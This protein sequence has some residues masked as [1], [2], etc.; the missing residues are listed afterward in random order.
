M[1]R[2]SRA[3][4]P[5]SRI[6]R[7]ALTRQL[8]RKWSTTGSNWPGITAILIQGGVGGGGG[9]FVDGGAFVAVSGGVALIGVVAAGVL[10]GSG[11]P[12]AKPATR[13]ATWES[14]WRRLWRLIVQSVQSPLHVST[15][16]LPP[17]TAQ[18]LLTGLLR[19]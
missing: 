19:W 12:S 17:R 18:E 13:A 1:I 16:C 9:V 3:F 7:R 10:S 11:S 2:R 6:C 4:F 5:I 8:R 15:S 14:R